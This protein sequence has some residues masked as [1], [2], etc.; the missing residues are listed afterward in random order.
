MPLFTA[1]LIF[2]SMEAVTGIY[3]ITNPNGET[4]IGQS[5]D[6]E[7]RWGQY[8]APSHDPSQTKIHHSLKTF[9]WENHHKTVI[10]ECTRAE[11]DEMEYQHKLA[12]VQERGWEK[13]LFCHLRDTAGGKNYAIPVIQYSLD[14]EPIKE[15]ESK[16]EAARQTGTNATS[17]W[18]CCNGTQIVANGFL[19][20][21]KGDPP[22]EPRKGHKQQTNSKKQVIARDTSGNVVYRYKSVAEATKSHSNAQRWLNGKAWDQSGLVWHFENE[23]PVK[24]K[25]WGPCPHCGVHFIHKPAN[26]ARW[27]YDN[28]KE[29]P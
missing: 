12:F 18:K 24:R 6:I 5:I 27:H 14:A 2:I 11:L 3:A 4:Y 7:K 13:A 17:I 25:N 28:C 16:I 19:W 20:G 8:R 9:G 29:A 10:H 22:P 1:G 21:H 15:F 23:E 26:M